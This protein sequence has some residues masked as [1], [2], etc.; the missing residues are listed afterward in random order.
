MSEFG[1]MMNRHRL[2]S[3][4]LGHQSLCDICGAV[5]MRVRADANGEWL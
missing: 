2:P 1:E 5:S 3:C 4:R